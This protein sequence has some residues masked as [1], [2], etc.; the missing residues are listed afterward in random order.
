MAS[1]T[2]NAQL[3]LNSLKVREV[4]DF[5][6]D[7]Y[8]AGGYR[9]LVNH[10][11]VTPSSLNLDQFA[12]MKSTWREDGQLYFC[13]IKIYNCVLSGA[14][15]TKWMQCYIQEHHLN[16]PPAHYPDVNLNLNGKSWQSVQN[17]FNEFC[18]SKSIDRL[19]IYSH[20]IVLRSVL[21]RRH[22][23]ILSIR[24]NDEQG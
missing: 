6:S 16:E 13:F 5:L 3:F 9:Y 8:A 4:K 10:R 1:S 18:V 20:H 19:T 24:S 21:G 17:R 22:L 11:H 2:F 15:L 7:V 14:F 23:P 12:T